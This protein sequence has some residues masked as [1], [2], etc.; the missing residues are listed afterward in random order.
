MTLKL[1]TLTI[2]S[3]SVG[4]SVLDGDGVEVGVHEYSRYSGTPVTG[5]KTE[6]HDG[7]GGPNIS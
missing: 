1:T 4:W 6:T 7:G 2:V 5:V 3:L